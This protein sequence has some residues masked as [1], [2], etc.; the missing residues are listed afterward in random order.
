MQNKN[1]L[2]KK[3]FNAQLKYPSKEDWISEVK[4]ILKELNI[5]KTFEEIKEMAKIKLTALTYG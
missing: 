4:I 1:Y 5:E 2:M 3:V